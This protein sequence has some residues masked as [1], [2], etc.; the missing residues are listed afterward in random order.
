M[1]AGNVRALTVSMKG[2]LLGNGHM[3]G[4]FTPSEEEVPQSPQGVGV[5]TDTQV[6]VGS[7]PSSAGDVPDGKQPELN[8]R[9]V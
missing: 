7:W 3:M 9:I 6:G 8:H 1:N 2:S 5:I 4:V